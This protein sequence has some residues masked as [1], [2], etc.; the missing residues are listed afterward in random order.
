MEQDRFSAASREGAARLEN[1]RSSPEFVEWRDGLPS[2]VLD[3]ERLYLPTGDVPVGELDLAR[4][5][6]RGEPRTRPP[7]EH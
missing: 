3:G 5:W 2:F 6:L 7:K 1:V 4:D